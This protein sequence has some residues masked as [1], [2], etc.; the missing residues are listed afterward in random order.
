MDVN[1]HRVVKKLS[2]FAISIQGNDIPT[3]SLLHI[4]EVF[5]MI[6]HVKFHPYKSLLIYPFEVTR[7][8]ELAYTLIIISF[9]FLCWKSQS[10]LAFRFKF[11][12]IIISNLKI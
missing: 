9:T 8:V 4:F 1:L 6:L 2:D 11:W 7:D 5:I 12:R 10:S 3:I